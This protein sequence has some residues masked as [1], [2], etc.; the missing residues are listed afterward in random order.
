MV[1]N[2]E[3]K[4]L[5]FEEG[6]LFY[7]KTEVWCPTE[8][9][10]QSLRGPPWRNSPTIL[11]SQERGEDITLVRHIQGKAVSARGRR[12]Q[13]GPRLDQD[14]CFIRSRLQTI[15]GSMVVVTGRE[16][17]R[18]ECIPMGHLCLESDR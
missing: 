3:N 1:S 2:R 10:C 12:D 9:Y 14:Q 18:V 7:D 5:I 13:D 11:G 8:P 15:S 16:H 6:V 4:G 17:R